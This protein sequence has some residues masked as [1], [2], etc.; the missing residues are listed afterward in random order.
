MT[1]SGKR[2]LGILLLA[3]MLVAATACG[4]SGPKTAPNTPEQIKADKAIAK[5]AVLKKSDLPS[6]YTATPHN[7]DPAND[8]PK[9]VLRKFAKCAKIPESKIDELI[10]GN[11]NDPSAPQVNSPD[12]S[13]DDKE[14]GISF[15]FE[16]S[17]EIDRS[18]KDISEPLD[19]LAGDDVL[20]CWKDLFKAAFEQEVTAPDEKVG[21]VAVTPID[22]GDVGDKSVSFEVRVLLTKGTNSVKAFFDAYFVQSGRAGISLFASGIRKSVDRDLSLFLLKAVVDR[23]KDAT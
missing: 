14:T 6:A 10:N 9:P 3:A 13:F 21:G 15:S 22:I 7:D 2:R 20:P 5:Q 8:T 17:V 11:D 16:N 1:S 12:F 19:L 4:S 23:M 18:S